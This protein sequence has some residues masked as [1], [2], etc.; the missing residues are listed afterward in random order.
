MESMECPHCGA[1]V[2]AQRICCASCG[3][4]L[5]TGWKDAGEIDYR[6]IELPEDHL[7]IEST[8]ESSKARMRSIGILLAFFI[9]APL[10]LFLFDNPLRVLMV[11][12]VLGLLMG[13]RKTLG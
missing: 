12:L 11:W 9:A 5:E 8:S 6:S 10:S 13:V 7:P 2:P 1:P 4:D 3:S